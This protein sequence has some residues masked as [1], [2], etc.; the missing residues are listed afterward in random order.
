[1]IIEGRICG[2]VVVFDHG[3]SLPDGAK[4]SVFV[5]EES[6][7][8]PPPAEFVEVCRGPK[9][10]GVPDIGDLF[11]LFPPEDLKEIKEAIQGCRKIDPDEW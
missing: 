1:M 8:A 11:G 2:G 7:S 9:S 6:L 3:G 5:R 4:V 10:A